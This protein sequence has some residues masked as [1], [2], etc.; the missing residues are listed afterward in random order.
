MKHL[1]CNLK[2]SFFKHSRALLDVATQLSIN[3]TKKPNLKKKKTRLECGF[4]SLHARSQNTVNCSSFGHVT[5]LR[6]NAC[7]AVTRG[8]DAKK[9]PKKQNYQTPKV[10]TCFSSS[11]RRKFPQMMVFKCLFMQCK[12]ASSLVIGKFFQGHRFGFSS[13]V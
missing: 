8:L 12:W 13:T 7:R 11:V 2:L 9:S 6:A 3:M 4:C 5:L 10:F 1:H